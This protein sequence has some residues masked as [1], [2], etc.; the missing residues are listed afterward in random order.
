MLGVVSMLVPAAAEVT[1]GRL[2]YSVVGVALD[3]AILVWGAVTRVRRRAV[4]GA[5]A[6]AVTL[7]IV[8]VVP[9]SGVVTSIDGPAMWLTLAGTGLLAIVV[10]AT[11][12]QGR[13]LVRSVGAR[14]REATADRE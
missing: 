11:L 14:L 7:A 3:T 9:L 13:Q 2:S 10:A 5:A 1:R 6:I 12:E 4:A 8:I